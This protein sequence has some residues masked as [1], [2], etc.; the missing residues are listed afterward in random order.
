MQSHTV[1]QVYKRFKYI[2]SFWQRDGSL[3]GRAS[4]DRKERK[5]D[6]RAVVEYSLTGKDLRCSCCSCCVFHWNDGILFR[7]IIR[8]SFSLS[9]SSVCRFHSVVQ[10]L[11]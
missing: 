11:W 9:D 8:G 5:W 10:Y 3:Y 6:T 1:F 7:G 2:N 4:M